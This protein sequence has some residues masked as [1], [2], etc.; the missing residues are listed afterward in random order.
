MFS[1][2]KQKTVSK[3][4]IP[5]KHSRELKRPCPVL[6]AASSSEN[7][8]SVEPKRTKKN[9]IG[10]KVFYTKLK[11]Q[12]III[13]DNV[14]P[15]V[16]EETVSD[17]D[18]NGAV[19]DSTKELNNNDNNTLDETA[20]LEQMV[21][22]ELK[23]EIPEVKEEILGQIQGQASTSSGGSIS[24][25]QWSPTGSVSGGVS[26]ETQTDHGGKE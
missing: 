20:W 26:C 6:D 19:S 7:I 10:S 11:D 1:G 4:E 18:V 14:P 22:E 17:D 9:Q 3:N 16:K 13:D 15:F 24:D 8:S 25:E 21:F 12:M 5:L 2:S 23:I